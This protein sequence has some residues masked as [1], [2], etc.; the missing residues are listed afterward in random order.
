MRYDNRVDAS[1]PAGAP[2]A[3]VVG[4]Y[5]REQAA[6]LAAR[7]PQVC[8]DE[9]DA[10]HKMRVATRR[11]RSALTTY[12]PL[13]RKKPTRTLKH[14]LTWLAGVLGAARDSEVLHAR[15]LAVRAGLPAQASS[16]STAPAPGPA[17][18]GLAVPAGHVLDRVA[19][20]LVGVHR[21]AMAEVTRALGSQ[22]YAALRE[23]LDA[24]VTRPPWKKVAARPAGSVL[25][26]FVRGAW[27]RVRRRAEAAEAARSHAERVVHLH[28]VRKAAKRARYAAESV[29]GV[30]GAPARRFAEAMQELQ[31]VL[32]EHQDSVVAQ[33]LV[34]D[35]GHPEL[36][37]REL[38][39]QREREQ[40]YLALWERVSSPELRG[41]LRT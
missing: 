18:A 3:E 37:E 34:E 11:L 26:R 10:V 12:R 15:V 35:L 24:Y 33:H 25:P 29:E 30:Y 5:L 20:H 13:L 32:G 23:R 16:P 28:E 31:D 9:P 40:E 2:A 19:E 36:V 39:L 21:D 7:A 14:E 17:T 38:A 27:K 1:T 4:G 22:R 41:W 6:E 8:R